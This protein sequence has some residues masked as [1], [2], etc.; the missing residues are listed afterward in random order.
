MVIWQRL[1]KQFLVAR[2]VVMKPC[3]DNIEEGS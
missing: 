3:G 1:V 2:D